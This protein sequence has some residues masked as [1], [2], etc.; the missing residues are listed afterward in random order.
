MKSIALSFALL[1]TMATS[2][3]Q[4]S[5]L[6]SGKIYV[7]GSFGFSSESSENESKF[8]GT[9]VKVDGPTTTSFNFIP[10]VN[11]MVSDKFSVGLAIGYIYQKYEEKGT[12]GFDPDFSV[13]NGAFVIAPMA[14]YFV[15]LGNEKFGL[16]FQGAVPLSFG[17][18]KRETT[19]G[20]TT[21]SREGSSNSFGVNISPGIFYFPSPKFM[22][23]ASLG[24]IVSFSSNTLKYDKTNT[25]SETKTTNTSFEIFNFSTNGPVS[26]G[27]GGLQ[28]GG[29]FFF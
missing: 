10:S 18:I 1:F 20:I 29:S 16:I 12:S 24:N 22:L 14:N 19:D 6:K 25:S 27:F 9:T 26:S 5:G 21:V 8:N 2:F 13:T 15:P 17:T 3:A 28:I 4:E 23:T 7:S 11:Y